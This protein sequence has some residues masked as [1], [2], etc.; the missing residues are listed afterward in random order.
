M[1]TDREEGEIDSELNQWIHQQG[2]IIHYPNQK[3]ILTLDKGEAI[4]LRGANFRWI[5]LSRPNLW[6]TYIFVWHIP[7]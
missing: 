7:R 1:D 4:P 2:T 6:Q 5:T 3:K